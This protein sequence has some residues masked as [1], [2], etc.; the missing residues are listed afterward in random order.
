MADVK[1]TIQ[2]ADH[3]SFERYG[4]RRVGKVVAWYDRHDGHR[5]FVLEVEGEM[6]SNASDGRWHVSEY[7]IAKAEGR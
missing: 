6:S 1:H 3:A 7:A 4:V 5:T 2:V